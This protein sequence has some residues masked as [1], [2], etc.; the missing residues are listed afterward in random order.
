MW[1]IR[2]SAGRLY[3]LGLALFDAL[4]FPLLALDGLIGGCWYGFLKSVVGEHAEPDTSLVLSAALLTSVVVD[5]LIVRSAWRAASRTVPPVITPNE[6]NPRNN[7]AIG[8]IALGLVLVSFFV[9]IGVFAV[10]RNVVWLNHEGAAWGAFLACIAGCVFG[11]IGRK[12]LPGKIAI[13][14]GGVIILLFL[15]VLLIAVPAK[16]PTEIPV[17][18][19]LPAEREDKMP[20]K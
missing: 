1:Q 17:P 6:K 13:G 4:L 16:S 12:T 9:F 10:G 3:G 15:V 14:F 2:R 19:K 5:F 18:A 11:L 8:Y 7:T 20:V